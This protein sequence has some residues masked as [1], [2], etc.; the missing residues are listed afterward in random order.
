[1]VAA[2][3]LLFLIRMVILLRLSSSPTCWQSL[4]GHGAGASGTA[5]DHRH[6]TAAVRGAE[7]P[8]SR[9]LHW[10]VSESGYSVKTLGHLPSLLLLQR[11]ALGPQYRE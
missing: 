3:C 9:V 7:D 11:G 6:R 4:R 2:C 10:W 1:M 5:Y 8:G